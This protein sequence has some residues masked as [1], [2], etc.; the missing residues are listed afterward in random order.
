M[1]PGS[2]LKGIVEGEGEGEDKGTVR[3]EG[4][5]QG[6]ELSCIFMI[7]YHIIQQY[8]KTQRNAAD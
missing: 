7:Q 3:G 4:R 1:D 8:S 5:Y 2:V 6:E